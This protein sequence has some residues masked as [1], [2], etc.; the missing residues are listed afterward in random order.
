MNDNLAPPPPQTEPPERDKAQ[1]APP[2][3]PPDPKDSDMGDVLHV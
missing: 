3:N 1:T 2:L